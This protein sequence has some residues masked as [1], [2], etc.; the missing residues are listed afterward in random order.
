[1]TR[2]ACLL[3]DSSASRIVVPVCDMKTSSSV[4][5]ETL[6]EPMPTPSS[7][8]SRGT[9]SSPEGTKKVTAPSDMVASTPNRSASAAR[10]ASSSSVWMRTR[11]APTCSLSASGV[12]RTTISPW[13]MIA[14]RSQN[15]ASSM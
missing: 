5:R 8:N 10:A 13:S 11:S 15:S 7:A 9:N 6:T 3:P 14:M 1:M 2:L 4:G 12:S